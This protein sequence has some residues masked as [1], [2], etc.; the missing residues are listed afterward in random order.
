MTI[1][2]MLVY[3]LMSTCFLITQSYAAS[4]ITYCAKT[5]Q[6]HNKNYTFVAASSDNADPQLAIPPTID[7]HYGFNDFGGYN[8]TIKKPCYAPIQNT[9][10]RPKKDQSGQICKSREGI[11]VKNCGFKKVSSDYCLRHIT[12]LK[13]P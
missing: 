5:Y 13:Q 10:W 3:T 1:N 2:R 8:V 4:N 9:Y 11:E 6:I 12:K 7:C